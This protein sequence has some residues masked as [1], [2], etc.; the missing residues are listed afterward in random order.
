MPNTRSDSSIADLPLGE[1]GTTLTWQEFG[2]AYSH[3]NRFGREQRDLTIDLQG[4]PDKMEAWRKRHG[5]LREYSEYLREGILSW[6]DFPR[7]STEGTDRWTRECFHEGLIG[8][9]SHFVQNVLPAIYDYRDADAPI[10]I[11]GETGTGKEIVARCIHRLGNRSELPFVAINCAG[12][13]EGL[14]ESLLFGIKG[15]TATGVSKDRKGIF[16]QA[17]AGTIFLDEIGEMPLHLQAKIL[18]VLNDGT[19]HPVGAQD[20]KPK[21]SKA[22]IISATNKNLDQAAKKGAFRSDLLY[23][24]NTLEIN[25]LPLYLR[26]GGLPL[27]VY[28]FVQLFNK[29]N[30]TEIKAVTQGFLEG[31]ALYRWPGGVR[32]LRSLIE[33]AC[34][35]ARNRPAKS[36]TLAELDV[37]HAIHSFQHFKSG[38]AYAKSVSIEKLR[39]FDLHGFMSRRDEYLH[40][41]ERGLWRM[42]HRLGV[43]AAEVEADEGGVALDRS[44]VETREEA[45]PEGHLREDSAFDRLIRVT[46]WKKALKEFQA[47]YVNHHLAEHGGKKS[48]AGKAI[49]LS[50]QR[51]GAVRKEA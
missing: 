19:F 40:P 32:E 24:L 11:R 18:R 9:D 15:G 20:W 35:I 49:G 5:L 43:L 30:G 25:L 45:T 47:Q 1:S 28:Y 17:A 46:P 34:I 12:L 4:W 41:Q 42:R 3:A 13:P 37:R 14:L 31:L 44:G 51:I 38:W 48:I 22:R 29:K 50:P 21:E 8:V 39:T 27:L 16:E 10:L 23:R 6:D 26:P 7:Y 2:S 36:D 33:R